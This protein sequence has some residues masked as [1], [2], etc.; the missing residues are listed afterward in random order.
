ME[1]ENA[2]RVIWEGLINE[3]DGYRF[4]LEAASRTNHRRG[5][6]MY[7]GLAADEVQHLRLFLVEYLALSKGQP[8]VDSR[9]AMETDLNFDMDKPD[10]GLGLEKPEGAVAVSQ[11]LFPDEWKH[12]ARIGSLDND[13]AALRFGMEIEE[14]AY[15][16]Y[17][18]AGAATSDPKA[19]E[20]YDF[21]VEE[22]R[23]HYQLIENAYYYLSDN[24]TWWD[25]DSPPFF[26][27]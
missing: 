6:E 13:L 8:W 16:L 15:K 18:G 11:K 3:R 23:R 4:Y 25:D 17:E 27:G 21:L 22:E 10:F 1:K 2:L 26:E 20:A 14:R 24:E 5:K 12:E 9:K 7:Q 19:K